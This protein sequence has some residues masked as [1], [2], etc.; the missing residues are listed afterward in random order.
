MIDLIALAALRPLRDAADVLAGLTEGDL[1][2]RASI[3]LS[4]DLVA[5]MVLGDVVDYLLAEPDND[6]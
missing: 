1:R 6:G 4:A 3:R 5:G 2:A